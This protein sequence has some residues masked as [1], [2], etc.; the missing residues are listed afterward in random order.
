MA[1]QLFSYESLVHALSG[2]CGSCTAMA[3]VLPLD[4]VRTRLILD[5][6]RWNK[7]ARSGLVQKIL[8]IYLGPENCFWLHLYYSCDTVKMVRSK[9][10]NGA[11][12]EKKM[13]RSM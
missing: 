9:A 10:K 7:S 1:K 8:S 11:K 12:E 5:K 13:V 3:I 4:T 2:V 6:H